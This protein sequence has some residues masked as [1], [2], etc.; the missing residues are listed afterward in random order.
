MHETS[1]K[2]YKDD[3]TFTLTDKEVRCQ[4]NRSTLLLF[5]CRLSRFLYAKI[6]PAQRHI[7]L[8]FRGD[9][10]HASVYLDPPSLFVWLLVSNCAEFL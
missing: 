8:S 2:H 7:F 9:R 5:F 10:G 1:G 3:L 4:S 6:G